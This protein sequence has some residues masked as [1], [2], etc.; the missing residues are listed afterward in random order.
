MHNQ[1]WSSCVILRT[2]LGY[3]LDSGADSVAIAFG[4]FQ[5][6][7]EPMP[8]RIAVI[9]PDFASLPMAVTTMS[10]RPSPSKSPNAHP[11]W[12][13]GKRIQT[14]LIR[15]HGPFALAPWVTEHK[16]GFVDVGSNVISANTWPPLRRYPSIRRCRSRKCL[17][18][19]RSA[20]GSP[21]VYR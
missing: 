4:P 19:S 15:Q 8:R 6:D 14:G 18:R 11:R 21:D 12:R 9:H 2:A 7:I 17:H 16:V 1:H 3:H 5:C 20:T 10:I 13:A